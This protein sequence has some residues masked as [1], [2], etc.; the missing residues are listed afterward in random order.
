MRERNASQLVYRT[1]EIRIA[2]AV[3]ASVGDHLGLS[4]YHFQTI[5]FCGRSSF[6]QS[7]ECRENGR[8]LTLHID[9][10]N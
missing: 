2:G 4:R 8:C 9:R 3:E 10:N 6:N 5:E 1:R 7:C